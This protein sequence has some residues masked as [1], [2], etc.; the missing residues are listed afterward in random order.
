M[1]QQPL[2][3]QGLLNIEGSRSQTRPNVYDSFGRVTSP[4]RDPYLTTHNAQ[5]THIHAPGG[6]RTTIPASEWQSTHALG[7]TGS[8]IQRKYMPVIIVKLQDGRAKQLQRTA[9]TP[10]EIFFLW[11]RQCG[12]AWN[13]TQSMSSRERW[14]NIP[15]KCQSTN[16]LTF[17]QLI[18]SRSREFPVLYGIRR[19]IDVLIKAH[20]KPEKSS[21]LSPYDAIYTQV[22][23][24]I[25]C[26]KLS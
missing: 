13:C 8:G 25:S 24:M 18:C 14:N 19:L 11:W 26:L 2:V 9:I 15:Y 4:R 23:Q 16:Q 7:C 5:Q 12:S 1:A 17:Q 21:Q 22:Y 20:Q 10:D 3:G 6:I